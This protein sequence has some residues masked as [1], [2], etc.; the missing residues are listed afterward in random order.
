MERA[1]AIVLNENNALEQAGGKDSVGA[2]W[3]HRSD[4]PRG[5]AAAIR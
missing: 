4:G 1:R 2:M 3:I 5:D